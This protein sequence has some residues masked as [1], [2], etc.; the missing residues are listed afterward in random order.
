M[1]ELLDLYPLDPLAP[2]HN[3][4]YHTQL[5]SMSDDTSPQCLPIQKQNPNIRVPPHHSAI[6][7]TSVYHERQD[8]IPMLAVVKAVHGC[9]AA[10]AHLYKLL[11][12]ELM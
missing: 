9:E 3:A 8:I 6:Y 1:K 11:A 2:H 5:C 12:Y 4:I 10:R 7:H